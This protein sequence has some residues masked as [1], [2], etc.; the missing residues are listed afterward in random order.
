MKDSKTKQVRLSPLEKLAS[1]LLSL[2]VQ[3]ENN[4]YAGNITLDE[5]GAYKFFPPTAEN[6]ISEGQKKNAIVYTCLSALAFSFIEPPLRSYKVGPMEKLDPLPARDPLQRL[7]RKPNPLMGPRIFG[8]YIAT[9]LGGGGN[10]YIVKLRGLL[11]QPVELWPFNDAQIEI[12][13]GSPNWIDHYCLYGKNGE[14]IKIDTK[15]VIHLK[16]P[17]P[18]PNYPWRA[19]APLMAAAREVAADNEMTR[20]IQA[21]LSNDAVIR[22]IV[23]VP[24]PLGE[25][26][27]DDLRRQWE[28][29]HGEEMRGGITV[30]E[31]GMEYERIG[32]NMQELAADALRRIPES[33]ITSSLRVPAQ[34]AG[35]WVGLEKSTYSN[36]EEANEAYTHKTMAPL[37][38]IVADELENELVPEFYGEEGLDKYRIQYDLSKVSALQEDQ[39]AKSTRIVAE[40]QAEIVELNEARAALGYPELTPEEL[41]ARDAA[42]VERARAFTEATKP[43]VEEDDEAEEGDEEEEDK[44]KK[45]KGGK[46]ILD[47]GAK[48]FELTHRRT[49]RKLGKEQGIAWGEVFRKQGKRIV[50]ELRDQTKAGVIWATKDLASWWNEDQERSELYAEYIK[51][52]TGAVNSG[53]A[54]A[55]KRIREAA[56]FDS[57]HILGR[58]GERVKD[59]NETTRKLLAQEISDGL[60][61]GYSTEQIIEGVEADGYAGVKGLFSNWENDRA[62]TVGRTESAIGYNLG[63][64]G[65]YEQA[66]VIFVRVHDGDFDEKCEAADGQIWTVREAA[67]HPIEHP[68]CIRGFDP[69]VS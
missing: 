34:V 44:P 67:D 12:V 29:E 53:V 66:G 51:I 4:L 37:W 58:L 24:F 15:D 48:G 32:L 33:R 45:P 42:K 10:C 55:Q 5:W 60:N 26:K 17:T 23:K 50:A 8:T 35:V 27:L 9:Y 20:Y 57:K 13:T 22:G 56:T 38:A 18:D 21:L 59:I 2:K 61:A 30:L 19:Q 62:K 52:S 36:F 63:S 68:N 3:G 49:L 25:G 46:K 14:K 39:N 43:S 40:L 16:W 11:G 54:A 7:L 28:R 6:L 41:A 65:Y 64:L 1:F 47:I 31:G 69:I